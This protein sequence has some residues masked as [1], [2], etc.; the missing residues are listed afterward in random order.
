MEKQMQSVLP[1]GRVET[2]V[3]FWAGRY[4]F[5]HPKRNHNFDNLSFE[6]QRFRV[7]RGSEGVGLCND[8]Y[9]VV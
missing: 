5:E 6:G 8:T 1:Y 2:V 3:P 4:Y 9:M 7:L